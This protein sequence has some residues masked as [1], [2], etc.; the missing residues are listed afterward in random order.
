MVFA[1]AYIG[2][3]LLGGPA[4]DTSQVSL[5]TPSLFAMA[6]IHGDFPR[7]TQALMHAGVIKDLSWALP[8]GSRFVQTGDIVDRGRDTR[9]L[10]H[11][12]RN[13][14]A[15]AEAAGG[16]V[17]KLW[18]NHEYMNA[19]LDWRYVDAG[20]YKTWPSQEARRASFSSGGDIFEDWMLDYAVTYRDPVYRA[21]FMHAGLHP[22]YRDFDSVDNV[23]RAFMRRA[24]D[25]HRD[26]SS[27]T[28]QEAAFW[29]SEGPMWFRGWALEDEAQA[30]REAQR[31][32]AKLDV[33]FLVVG[34]TPQFDGALAR[35]GGHVILLDTGMSS[36]Y[37]GPAVVLEFKTIADASGKPQVQLV[38]HYDD[39]KS[40]E[41]VVVT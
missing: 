9:Q 11:F 22:D 41:I 19:L 2:Q 25:G 24:G 38:L 4:P 28:P 34:H 32:M 8:S 3:L 17:H 35:C 37:G 23:G 7:A 16:E 33:D 12:M 10:Y 18:G 13:L 27:W 15:Q 21:H 31:T 5:D 20:D 29:S 40:R 1:L 36:A 39:D 30:C 14:T 26:H 6:D